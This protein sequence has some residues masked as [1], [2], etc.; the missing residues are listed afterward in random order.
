M[1]YVKIKVNTYFLHIYSNYELRYLFINIRQQ[2][3]LQIRNN[4]FFN[5][6]TKSASTLIGGWWRLAR[7]IDRRTTH[8]NGSL[9][10]GGILAFKNGTTFEFS[11]PFVLYTIYKTLKYIIRQ[12]KGHFYCIWN[13]W[14][15]CI[16]LVQSFLCLRSDFKTLYEKIRGKS[17]VVN[18]IHTRQIFGFFSVVRM[19][20]TQHREKLYL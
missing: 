19:L 18:S 14:I 3:V 12:V 11:I 8:S 17:P 7:G 10:S 2:F 16:G 1:T 5:L 4:S 15:L 6:I 9:R 13:I 20:L